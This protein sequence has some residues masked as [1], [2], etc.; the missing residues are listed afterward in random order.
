MLTLMGI[1]DRVHEVHEH[2]AREA[3]EAEIAARRDR[4]SQAEREVFRDHWQKITQAVV[5]SGRPPD[6][7]AATPA[8]LVAANRVIRAK[9][10]GLRSES[11]LT[12]KP[13]YYPPA[14]SLVEAWTGEVHAARAPHLQPAWDMES[15][16]L[17]AGHSAEDDQV[18][19]RFSRSG[20]EW[21]RLFLGQ[22]ATIYR[23]AAIRSPLEDTLAGYSFFPISAAMDLNPETH[24]AIEE[25][26]AHMV[27]RRQLDVDLTEG[28]S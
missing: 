2:D 23:G 18:A 16:A 5:A 4:E 7:Q 22:D 19:F 28:Q 3:R 8:G 24:L 21:D 11:L 10:R 9:P 25:A 15:Y 17:A 26:L 13:V 12:G 6:A 20:R 27:V 1:Q 14:K